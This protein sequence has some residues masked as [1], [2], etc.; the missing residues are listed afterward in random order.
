MERDGAK[1][2]KRAARAGSGERMVTRAVRPKEQATS[3][4][5]PFARVSC[6]QGGAE[7]R[8]DE[9]EEVAREEEAT[10]KESSRRGQMEERS[11]GRVSKRFRV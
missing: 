5:L 2:Q 8:A 1:K 11:D 9:R 6:V 3:R 10:E 7:V 4:T